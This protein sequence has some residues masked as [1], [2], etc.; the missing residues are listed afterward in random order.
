MVSVF[1]DRDRT[2]E[3]QSTTCVAANGEVHSRFPDLM[4]QC[5]E[6]E[7][8]Y[9]NYSYKEMSVVK[10]IT[11]KQYSSNYRKLLTPR[12]GYQIATKKFC[13]TG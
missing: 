6:G 10:V 3:K 4:P 9:Y 12:Q 7:S 5:A 1:S 8:P 11:F 13:L 2:L